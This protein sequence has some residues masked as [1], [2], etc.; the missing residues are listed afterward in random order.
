[1]SQLPV[2]STGKEPRVVGTLT[3]LAI[4]A[5]YNSATVKAE[6]AEDEQRMGA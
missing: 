2:L 4:D 6:I 5:A 1:V 3:E